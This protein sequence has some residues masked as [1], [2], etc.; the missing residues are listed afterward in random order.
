M[1]L[2]QGPQRSDAGEARTRGAGASGLSLN[3]SHIPKICFLLV[4]L[5]YMY[6]KVV[7]SLFEWFMQMRQLLKYTDGQKK[8]LQL[9][10]AIKLLRRKK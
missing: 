7:I 3:R 5:S 10:F 2:A 4:L 8:T 1:C 6:V 9:R